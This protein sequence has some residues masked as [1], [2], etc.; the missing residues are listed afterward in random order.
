MTVIGDERWLVQW[1]LSFGGEAEVIEP[2]W[3]RQAV[4]VAALRALEGT[5]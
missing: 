1:L 4:A 2:A 5:R 3:A